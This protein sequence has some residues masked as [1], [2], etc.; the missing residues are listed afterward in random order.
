MQSDAGSEPQREQF[1]VGDYQ[2]SWV[3]VEGTL[4]PSLMGAGPSQAQ[5]NSRLIGAV[6]EGPG[7]PWFFKVTGPNQTVL[8]AREQIRGVIESIEAA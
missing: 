1:Q 5:P 8:D 7:G 2:V 6:V 4:L 3:E